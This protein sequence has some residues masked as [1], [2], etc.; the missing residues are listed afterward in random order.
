MESNC[1]FF[2]VEVPFTLCTHHRVDRVLGFFSS[3]PNWD[4]PTP[5]TPSVCAPPRFG[6]G[7]GTLACGRRDV[8]SK[9]R[10]GDRHSGTLDINL[11]CRAQNTNQPPLLGMR[12]KTTFVNLSVSV[13]SGG[14]FSSY[15]R[16]PYALPSVGERRFLPLL[17]TKTTFVNL[18]FCV[19]RRAFL[20]LH[21]DPVRSASGGGE[22]VPAPV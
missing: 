4:S 14:R 20:V 1:V 19:F 2:R 7:G 8:G 17:R 10:R 21:V 12:T 11:I 22:E 6:G 3:R 18:C 16:I 9:F 15:T 13:C 5:S